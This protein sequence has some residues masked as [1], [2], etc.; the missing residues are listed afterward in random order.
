MM[1]M[2][3]NPPKWR[4][5]VNSKVSAR[6]SLISVIPGS[7]VLQKHRRWSIQVIHHHECVDVE[8]L[9]SDSKKI[10]RSGCSSPSIVLIPSSS[11]LTSPLQFRRNQDFS[12]SSLIELN[13]HLSSSINTQWTIHNCSQSSSLNCSLSSM[14]VKTQ[15]DPSGIN[16]NLVQ[17]G[18]SMI[19]RGHEQPLILDPGRFSEDLDEDIFN[20]SVRILLFFF[21]WDQCEQDWNYEYFCRI[22]AA[23]SPFP[24]SGGILIP[25]DDPQITSMNNSCFFP[26]QTLSKSIF[27]FASCHHVFSFLVKML[28]LCGD[29]R[30]TNLRW[31]SSKRHSNRIERINGWC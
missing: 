30:R 2:I 31:R 28:N 21:D 3:N 11:R 26:R 24:H 1:M 29:S 14:P 5:Q 20:A 19:T 27:V 9:S 6:L 23:Q 10:D 17:F 12:I 16:A 22:Y 25:I 18:T 13:C 7:I 4:A 15:I 8:D